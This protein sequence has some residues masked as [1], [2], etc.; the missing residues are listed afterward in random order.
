MQGRCRRI[1]RLAV[2]LVAACGSL[3]D[4]PKMPKQFPTGAAQ[5]ALNR[6][7]GGALDAEGTRMMLDVG[8]TAVDAVA[9]ISSAAVRIQGE[10][11]VREVF[12]EDELHVL[13]AA[14]QSF[15]TD[16]CASAA[17]V[18]PV[19]GADP[20]NLGD[21]VRFEREASEAFQSANYEK[22]A[23]LLERVY[24]TREKQ[25]GANHPVVL[26]LLNKIAA[27]WL[28]DNNY[29]NAMPF[30]MKAMTRREQSLHSIKPTTSPGHDEIAAA[31]AVGESANTIANIYYATAQYSKARQYYEHAIELCARYL[32]V[33]HLCTA[34]SQSGLG[35][36][37]QRMGDYPAARRP[38]DAALW[39][40]QAK[41]GQQ[42]RDTAR[43]VKD[44]AS[45]YRAI[46]DLPRAQELYRRALD[47][48][49]TL[50]KDDVDVAESH[51]DLGDVYKLRG[52]YV[53][54]E[55]EYQ[56]RSI[57]PKEAQ[58]GSRDRR[59]SECTRGSIRGDGGLRP[60]TGTVQH[61]LQYP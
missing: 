34:Q 3:P 15:Y 38:L 4:I 58:R 51:N 39:I 11:R 44:L 35:E 45:F 32:G 14:T 36:L 30:A 47:L 20:A 56:K 6:I 59:V 24:K 7:T 53:N 61:R 10:I 40:R 8:P 50:G 52:D 26:S 57:S 21:L 33:D 46:G 25:L 27:I 1:P 28:A 12:L 29:V 49:L 13:V 22:A 19:A 43:S 31:L 54:A 42:H 55:L 17:P 2:L 5:R 23:S 9:S 48:R 18:P 41:L 60:R 16:E 37:L